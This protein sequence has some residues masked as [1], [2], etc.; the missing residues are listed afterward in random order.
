[1]RPAPSRPADVP[2]DAAAQPLERERFG[3]LAYRG[4]VAAIL[5][6]VALAGLW[7]AHEYPTFG[8]YDV[9]QHE[10]YA[11]ELVTNWRL[12][13]NAGRTAYYKPPGFYVLAGAMWK[14]GGALHLQQPHK[15]TQ[16]LNAALVVATALL[17][18]ALAR[19]LWPERRAL[20]VAALAFF[21]LVPVVLKTAAMVHPAT[22]G[23]FIS[24]LAVYLAARML[25]R[26]EWGLRWSLAL[27]ATL[28]AGVLVISSNL[29][30]YG[31]VLL[32]L[33]V[34]AIVRADERRAI[35]RTGGVVV[36]VT[37][38]LAA[39]W[40]VRQAVRY[41]NPIL[42]ARPTAAAPVWE[43]RPAE[44]YTG[45]GWPQV[46]TRPYT[47][48][49]LNELVPTT[50]SELWGDYFGVFAWGAN[51]PP[52]SGV[53]RDLTQQ[54]ELGL[55]PTIVALIG[56][57]GVAW[58]LR[59]RRALASQTARLVVVALPLVA[60]LGYLYYVVSYPTNDGDVL[61]A[62]FMLS[63]A[64]CWALAFGWA[65]DRA[66]A[67]RFV[68]PALLLALIGI[69]LLDLRFVVFHSPLGGLL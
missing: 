51:T 42:G 58:G 5:V 46:F 48:S 16:F 66:L 20:H 62:T 34:A 56:L 22:T 33:A 44:F 6:V 65:V 19:L 4:A 60:L 24:T 63:A 1:M 9:Q 2:T 13:E 30:T 41:G 3:T 53:K 17:V 38:L 27:T 40:Y 61:K 35:L 54:N 26:H 18:L 45:L 55:L 43:R 37:V 49:F 59:H 47:P 50:Y 31:V 10:I 36:L 68:R 67:Y 32:V 25:V 14:L 21:A 29:W 11:E 12:P 69:A 28:I 8:G 52:D 57:G 23:L 39:P 64:P 15:P 7:N